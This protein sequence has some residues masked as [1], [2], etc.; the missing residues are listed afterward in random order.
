MSLLTRCKGIRRYPAVVVVI[1]VASNKLSG[2]K[3][4]ASRSARYEFT[5]KVV[6]NVLLDTIVF[7]DYRVLT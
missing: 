2:R 1:S 7:V 4:S 6:N 5:I 3:A